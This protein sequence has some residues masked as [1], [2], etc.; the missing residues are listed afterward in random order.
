MRFLA[1][2]CLLTHGL[3]SVTNEE[4]AAAWPFTDPCL[5]WVENGKI[6][7]GNME[8]FLSFRTNSQNVIRFDC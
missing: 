6:I 7:H 1:E 4:M 2:T 3:R 5:V 8:R